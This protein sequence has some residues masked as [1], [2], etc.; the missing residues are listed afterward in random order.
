MTDEPRSM[1]QLAQLRTQ[2]HRTPGLLPA[3]QA[4]ALDW[5]CD[6]NVGGRHDYYN[7]V[8]G[9][10]AVA[11]RA[12]ARARERPAVRRAGIRSSP[13][14][15][16][17]AP[18]SSRAG[19]CGSA[20]GVV[21]LLPMCVM[22]DDE[23]WVELRF[24]WPDGRERRLDDAFYLRDPGGWSPN[25]RASLVLADGAFWVLGEEPPESVLELFA[26]A[27]GVPLPPKSARTRS[28]SWRRA[29]R[30]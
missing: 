19:R 27:G 16:R 25:A 7:G 22:R 13:P 26:A 2:V 20:P 1:M 29:S 28:G 8:T 24:L 23:V 30:I 12:P 3:E 11:P 5:L 10:R 14:S 15:S 9:D 6:H 18:A 21:R 4:A 17:R